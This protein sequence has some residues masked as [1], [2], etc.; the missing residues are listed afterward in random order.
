MLETRTGKKQRFC[1]LQRKRINRRGLA[2]EKSLIL[3]KKHAL[4]FCPLLVSFNRHLMVRD[5]S[6]DWIIENPF[7]TEVGTSYK[8]RTIYVYSNY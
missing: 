2:F 4:A 7:E 3:D 1:V 5:L 6:Q 8:M